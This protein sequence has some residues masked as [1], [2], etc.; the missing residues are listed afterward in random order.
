VINEASSGPY[1]ITLQLFGTVGY[2]Y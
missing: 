1:F 2:V